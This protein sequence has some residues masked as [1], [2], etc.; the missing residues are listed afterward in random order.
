MTVVLEFSPFHWAVGLWS[1]SCCWSRKCLSCHHLCPKCFLGLHFWLSSLGA[2][3]TYMADLLWLPSI[4]TT[5]F[6]ISILFVFLFSYTFLVG[7]CFLVL[8]FYF[9]SIES[10]YI[11][12]LFSWPLLFCFSPPYS[13]IFIWWHFVQLKVLCYSVDFECFSSALH[14]TGFFYRYKIILWQFFV[15]LLGERWR[16]AIIFCYSFYSCRIFVFLTATP[17][18]GAN[19]SLRIG[20]SFVLASPSK[21][22]LL[23]GCLFRSHRLSNH[24]P[25]SCAMNHYVLCSVFWNLVLRFFFLRMLF[26]SC[27]CPS[28]L[29]PLEFISLVKATRMLWYSLSPVILKRWVIHGFTSSDWSLF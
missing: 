2:L 15:V 6:F 4:S 26:L 11:F 1:Y 16:K 18:G 19:S 13:Q 8:F 28:T 23:W 25:I 3:I 17:L 5:I 10:L 27:P 9:N 29:K 12:F 14:L 24:F 22:M 21:A 7:F 20:F